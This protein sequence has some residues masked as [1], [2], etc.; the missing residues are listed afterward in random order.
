MSKNKNLTAAK[1]AKNDEFFTLIEDVEKEVSQYKDQ[2]KDKVI[3]CNC[4]DY[5]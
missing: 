3:Y 1:K 2:F 4:D 5:K